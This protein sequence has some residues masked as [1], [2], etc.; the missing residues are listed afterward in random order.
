MN[1]E[2]QVCSIDN[3]NSLFA[4]IG[5]KDCLYY[6]SFNYKSFSDEQIVDHAITMIPCG[7]HIPAYTSDELLDLLPAF[8]YYNLFKPHDY[9][10]LRIDKRTYKDIRYCAKYVCSSIEGKEINNPFFEVPSPAKSHASTLADCLAE[11]LI[12]LLENKMMDIP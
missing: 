1:L 4:L 9:Y 6:H 10:Y 11:M 5:K 2:D 3:A 8:I 12:Y 7:E